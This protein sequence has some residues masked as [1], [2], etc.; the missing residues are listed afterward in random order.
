[1]FPQFATTQADLVCD[2]VLPIDQMREYTGP[3]SLVVKR[4]PKEVLEAVYGLALKVEN[5]EEDGDG[6]VTAE[7][8]LVAYASKCKRLDAFCSLFS[9]ADLSRSRLHEIWTG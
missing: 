9:S 2:G 4:I 3:I 8:L 7:S 6:K 5:A 1:M